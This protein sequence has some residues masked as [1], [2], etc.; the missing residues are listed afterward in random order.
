[1]SKI[2]WNRPLKCL[3]IC[4]EFQQFHFKAGVYILRRKSYPLP[5]FENHIFPLRRNIIL[6]VLCFSFPHQLAKIMGNIFLP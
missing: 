5:P 1:M 4:L 6:G 2:L 3:G